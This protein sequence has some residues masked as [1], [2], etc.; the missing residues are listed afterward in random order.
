MKWFGAITALFS[1]I[2]GMVQL[3]TLIRDKINRDRAVDELVAAARYQAEAKDLDGAWRLADQAMQL[4]PVA[5]NIRR[6]QVELA[7]QRVRK[8]NRIK[9]E[10]WKETAKSLIPILHRGVFSG[11]PRQRA[12]VL[13]HLARANSILYWKGDTWIDADRHFK[14]ALDLDPENVFAHAYYGA[15]ILDK[16]DRK[17]NKEK[18]ALALEH[19]RL[20]V[21]SGREYEWARGLQVN[22]LTSFLKRNDNY[23]KSHL[24]EIGIELIA[25]GEQLRNKPVKLSR[26]SYGGLAR[27]FAFIDRQWEM[28]DVFFQRYPPDQVMDIYRFLC[29]NA[30]KLSCS[31]SEPSLEQKLFIE[32]LLLEADGQP[33]KAFSCLTKIYTECGFG[34]Y[35]YRQKISMVRERLWKAQGYSLADTLCIQSLTQGSPA[36]KGG[37]HL[38][39]ILLRIADHRVTQ[40][41]DWKTVQA[42]LPRGTRHYTVRLLRG[43]QVITLSV[44]NT[45]L[46]GVEGYLCKVP[47]KWIDSNYQQG[48]AITTSP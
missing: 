45:P 2:F 42:S 5:P 11:T 36:Y 1:L 4:S 20:A 8:I 46:Q 12:D 38:E 29:A 37:M 9:R 47:Q 43:R 40:I 30:G 39:D 15:F 7:M 14:Q 44:P 16:E 41:E 19:F 23:S 48:V 24:E 31:H 32:A 22:R 10:H 34:N 28:R 13:A 17:C 33:D 26:L 21:Q 6:F 3:N 35:E 18:M 27:S 25:V